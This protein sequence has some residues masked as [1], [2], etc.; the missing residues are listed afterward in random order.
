MLRILYQIKAQTLRFTLTYKT[1]ITN[2]NLS[3]K[4]EKLRTFSTEKIPL[5]HFFSN[6]NN[7]LLR[8]AYQ[9]KA[10]TLR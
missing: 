1:S 6:F 5:S 3:I 4:T 8:I 10:H 7:T 9:I 2:Q